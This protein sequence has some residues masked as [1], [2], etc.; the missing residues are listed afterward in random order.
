MTD[1]ELMKAARAAL[2][3]SQTAASEYL[4]VTVAQISAIENGRSRLTK[5]LRI[6]IAAHIAER[7]ARRHTRWK[8]WEGPQT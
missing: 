3:W 5:T 1:A 6:L 7:D 8:P 2:L 4:G